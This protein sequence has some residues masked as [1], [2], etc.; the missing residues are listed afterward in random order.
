ME[1]GDRIRFKQ[2]REWHGEYGTVTGFV[3]GRNRVF[4]MP[5][6]TTQRPQSDK[7][8]HWGITE[9]ELLSG[10]ICAE[11][12]ATFSKWDYLCEACRG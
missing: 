6:D 9:V 1:V 10:S 8:W 3:D 4:I 5:D 2:H 11:C 7:G 12:H